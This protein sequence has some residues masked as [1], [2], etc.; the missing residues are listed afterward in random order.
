MGSCRRETTE[1]EAGNYSGRPQ[2]QDARQCGGHIKT[3]HR[4]ERK[5]QALRAGQIHRGPSQRRAEG[6]TGAVPFSGAVEWTKGEDELGLPTL[7]GEASIPARNLN[8]SLTIRK[9]SDPSLPASHLLEVNF[10]VSDTFVGGSISSLPGVLLKDEEL[11]PGT[12]LVGAS[13]RIMGNSFLFALSASPDDEAFNAQLLE[14]RRWLDLAMV[15][16]TGRNAILTLE[17]DTDAQA[18]FKEV[19]ATWAQ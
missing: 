17:K 18:L 11:V 9:N 5:R 19:F 2:S 10:D 15:Y 13:A 7:V 14:Q 1:R 8:V 4:S 12:P 6:Q 16:G 3:E